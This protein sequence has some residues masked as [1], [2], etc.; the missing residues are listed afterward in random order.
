LETAFSFDLIK[1]FQ[2]ATL[3]RELPLGIDLI[4]PIIKLFQMA[5]PVALSLGPP[6]Q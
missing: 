6:A 4:A 2:M 1:W 5:G 3:S